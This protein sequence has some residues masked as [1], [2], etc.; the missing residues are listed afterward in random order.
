MCVTEHSGGRRRA[1]LILRIV[2]ASPCR[3]S[4]CSVGSSA[5]RRRTPWS[6][7]STT[8][9]KGWTCL[10]PIASRGFILS[11]SAPSG[12][13][14]VSGGGLAFCDPACPHNGTLMLHSQQGAVWTFEEASSAPFDLIAFEGAEAHEGITIAWAA[15]IVVVGTRSGGGNVEASFALDFIQDAEGG[16]ADF[17]KFVLPAGFTG[18][19]SVAF[20]GRGSVDEDQNFFNI[21]NVE[22]EVGVPEPGASLLL[23]CG[24]VVLLG[25]RRL[26][27]AG[28][29]RRSRRAAAARRRT[30]VWSQP[31]ASI[32]AR[33]SA[34]SPK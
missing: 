29:R 14:G 33:V 12:F 17:E 2:E 15:E 5:P 24:A 25:S 27:T 9:K 13:V 20:S 16:A 3:F 1:A 8:S 31:S 30:P 34:S 18:L 6:S 22:V 19:T 11:N 32:A 4:S 23:A 28:L 10:P 26:H 21:D 7:T